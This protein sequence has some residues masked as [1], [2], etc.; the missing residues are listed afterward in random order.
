MWASSTELI[1]QSAALVEFGSGA[2]IKVQ[3]L[4]D[5]VPAIAAYLPVD[6][7]GD[8]LKVQAERVSAAYP[9]L[10]VHPV[11][12]DFTKPFELPGEFARDAESRIFPGLDLRQFRAA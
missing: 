4:L 10:I 8:F 6:I 5:N 3:I 1:P 9:R 12:A 7:S 11:V 2:C